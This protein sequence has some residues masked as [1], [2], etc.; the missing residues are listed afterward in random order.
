LDFNG[1]RLI[2]KGLWPLDFNGFPLI[3]KG[4]A[5]GFQWISA[6]FARLGPL[7][8]NG[9]RSFL[10]GLLALEF[11]WNSVDFEGACPW[12]SIDFG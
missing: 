10:K 12:I 9:F 4:L 3:L 5:P 6:Y 2:L 1:F 8:F 11:Q 7:D